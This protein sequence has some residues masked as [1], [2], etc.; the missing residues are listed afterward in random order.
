MQKKKVGCSVVGEEK[1]NEAY[2]CAG[3]TT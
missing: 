2:V 3:V 1:E